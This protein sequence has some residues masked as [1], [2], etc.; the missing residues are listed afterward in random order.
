[1]NVSLEKRLCCLAN[2]FSG[3]TRW[4]HRDGMPVTFQLVWVMKDCTTPC[5][6]PIGKWEILVV[7]SFPINQH[8][9]INTRCAANVKTPSIRPAKLQ[10]RISALPNHRL[11]M[12][13]HAFW[14]PPVS[15]LRMLLSPYIYVVWWLIIYNFYFFTFLS[16]DLRP[17]CW[18]LAPFRFLNLFHSP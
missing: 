3:M 7:R 8:V 5:H 1:M 13:C 6:I 2:L 10:C 15:R 12:L 16:M 18:T 17:F 11:H 4:P 9:Q 14:F